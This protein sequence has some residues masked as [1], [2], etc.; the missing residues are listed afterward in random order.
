MLPAHIADQGVDTTDMNEIVS[1]F[2]HRQPYK[3]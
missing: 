2:L 3:L 1:M